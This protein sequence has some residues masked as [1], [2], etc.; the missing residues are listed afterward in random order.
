MSKHIHLNLIKEKEILSSSP[1]RTQVIAPIILAIIT[2]CTLGWWFLLFMQYTGTKKLNDHLNQIQEQ[3]QPEYKQVL[4]LN[5]KEKNVTALIAQLSAYK[6]SKLF[7]GKTFQQ[8]PQHVLPNIQFTKLELLQPARPLLEKDKE[9]AGPTNKTESA[10]FV[11]TGRTSGANAFDA[12]D[13]LL[14]DLKKGKFT[15]LIQSAHI[16][17]GSL[18]QDMKTKKDESEFL[19]FELKCNCTPRRFE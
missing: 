5:T 14:S 7:Y 1:V 4:A 8:I 19:R 3:L 9:S 10:T 6:N 16:P 11:I 12:V 17:K 13:Q 2:A 18:R 15:N